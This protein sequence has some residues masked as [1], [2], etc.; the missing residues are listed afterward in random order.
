MVAVHPT[1]GHRRPRSGSLVSMALRS[2]LEDASGAVRQ[3]HEDAARAW[4]L[5]QRA[6]NVRDHPGRKIVELD[7]DARKRTARDPGARR[8]WADAQGRQLHDGLA[9]EVRS[10]E[11]L[12]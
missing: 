12:E 4:Q 6:R 10:T 8:G 2:T 7:A 1:P 11:R 3:T 9:Q 5:E